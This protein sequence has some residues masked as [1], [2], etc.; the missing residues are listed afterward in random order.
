MHMFYIYWDFVTNWPSVKRC[1]MPEK[2]DNEADRDLYG[3]NVWARF[4][5]FSKVYTII[6]IQDEPIESS[7]HYMY[8]FIGDSKF[9]NSYSY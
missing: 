6:M 8:P 7:S 1:V 9:E 2:C 3:Q 4:N 5:V